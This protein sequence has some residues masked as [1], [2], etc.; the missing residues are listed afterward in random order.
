MSLVRNKK[1]H[2]TYTILDTYEAGIQ[3][4]GVETKSV[5]AGHGILDGS[6]VLIRG[7][8]AFLVGAQI[9]AYQKANAPKDYDEVR[10]RKLLLNKRQ[11][12]S[13]YE[14]SSGDGLTVVPISLYNKGV[15]IK[16]EV[17]LVKGKKKHDK[18]ETLK[19]QDAKREGERILKSSRR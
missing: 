7:G 9:P 16:C 10:T 18:R 12:A 3:L 15:F 11:I 2:L 14:G 1:V 17:A 5:R 13:L 4:L 6:R 8:E 19:K